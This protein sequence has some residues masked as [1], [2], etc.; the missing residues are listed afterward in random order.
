[1][2]YLITAKHCG[3]FRSIWKQ[4]QYLF[5]SIDSIEPVS[6]S[7]IALHGTLA[8]AKSIVGFRIA[9]NAVSEKPVAVRHHHGR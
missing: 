7:S 1:L 5:S 3:E 8:A 9:F 2:T 6:A 4:Y